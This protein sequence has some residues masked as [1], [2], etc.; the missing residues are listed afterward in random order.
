MKTKQIFILQTLTLKDINQN[1][2]NNTGGNCDGFG[3]FFVEVRLMFISDVVD[4]FCRRVFTKKLGGG[5]WQWWVRVDGTW[6]V[7][8]DGTWWGNTHRRRV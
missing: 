6:W 4:V 1:S 2:N 8:V 7:R 5:C 3:E